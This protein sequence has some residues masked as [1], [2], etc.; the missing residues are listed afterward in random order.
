MRNTPT[1]GFISRC[2]PILLFLSGAESIRSSCTVQRE[3]DIIK[4]EGEGVHLALAV[5]IIYVDMVN[6]S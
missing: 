3:R 6:F 5:V 1:W 4:H 2:I